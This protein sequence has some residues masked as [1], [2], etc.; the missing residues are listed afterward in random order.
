MMFK[1]IT[2]HLSS[3]RVPGLL[4]ISGSMLFLCTITA[5]SGEVYLEWDA[6]TEVPNLSGYQVYYG[7]ASGKYTSNVDVSNQTSYRIGNLPDGKTYYFAI[8]AYGYDS[9]GQTIQGD[10]S[11]E[12]SQ[13]IGTPLEGNN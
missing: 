11:D 4:V 13:T 3:S 9:N 2:A 6:N 1:S 12:I 8:R 7:E 5:Q 10:F